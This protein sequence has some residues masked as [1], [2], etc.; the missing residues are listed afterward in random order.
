MVPR[1]R[2]AFEPDQRLDLHGLSGDQ[3]LRRLAQ[4]L[5]AA[6]V[7][8]ARKVLVIT[9]RGWGSEPGRGPVLGPAV[10]AWLKGEEGQRAGVKGVR[11]DATG[12]AFE[13]E[14]AG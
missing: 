6:R 2:P 1:R 7:R 4:D 10:R 3:A 13:V 9:G 14:L 12:G 11:P 8:G 5:H